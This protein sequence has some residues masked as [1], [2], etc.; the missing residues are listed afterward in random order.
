MASANKWYDLSIHN[1]LERFPTD[2]PDLEQHHCVAPYITR[3][4]VLPVD[5]SLGAEEGRIAF[6]TQIRTL[7][8]LDVMKEL[9]AC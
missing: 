1:I 4:T 8:T 6:P 2:R 9:R 3:H 5:K 7:R